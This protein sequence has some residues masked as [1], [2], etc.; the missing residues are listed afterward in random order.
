MAARG[1]RGTLKLA[2]RGEKF[3]EEQRSH[4][5]QSPG[6]VEDDEELERRLPPGGR[7]TGGSLPQAAF[8][9]REL[10]WTEEEGGASV[11]RSLYAQV[12][13]AGR[14]GTRGTIKAR[15]GDIRSL[16]DAEGN[17]LWSITD[18]PLP[19]N[20]AHAEIQREPRGKMP[21]RAE[22]SQLLEVWRGATVL[23]MKLRELDP[24]GRPELQLVPDAGVEIH[25]RSGRNG[26]L[27]RVL[28]VESVAEAVRAY[29]RAGIIAKADAVEEQHKLEQALASG[30]QSPHTSG[31]GIG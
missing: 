25:W 19:G 20:S 29:V 28:Q 12:G 2:R 13:I 18:R 22:R 4:G 10:R 8:Q 1:A 21:S 7:E 26:N 23:L 16:T 17:R 14:R 5:A 9:R 30:L 15:A 31:T 27:N 24:R 11:E 6:V 3:P